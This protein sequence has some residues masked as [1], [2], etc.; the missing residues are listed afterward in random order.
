[1]N[2]FFTLQYLATFA[3]MV[4]AVN[5]LT[6]ATKTFFNFS[7]RWLVLAYAVIIQGFVLLFTGGFTGSQVFLGIIN[8]VLVATTAVGTYQVVTDKRSSTEQSNP[9][10]EEA[11]H[12][13]EDY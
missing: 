6:Q 9:S 11:T 7:T 13:S 10:A 3:G 1:M 4:L 2:D 8:A 5:L 12:D